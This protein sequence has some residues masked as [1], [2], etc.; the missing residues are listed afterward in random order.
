ML[1]ID[2]RHVPQW[3]PNL[4]VFTH[5]DSAAVK[6]CILRGLRLAADSTP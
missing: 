3:K 2:R 4:D 5:C 6:D 1:V